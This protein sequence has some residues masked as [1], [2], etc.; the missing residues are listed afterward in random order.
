MTKTVIYTWTLNVSNYKP[1]DGS[2]Y[3]GIGD[4]LRGMIAC[5]VL[6]KKHNYNYIIDIQK[7]P[8]SKYLKQNN[9]EFIE[10]V[11]TNDDIPF[12]QTNEL[13]N[14]IQN[15]DQNVLMLMTNSLI[16]NN[17]K[18]DDDIKTMIMNIF[19]K[20]DSFAKYYEDC[21]Q[22]LNLDDEYY[23]CHFRLGDD[24]IVRNSSNINKV[25]QVYNKFLKDK[26]L[27]KRN[28]LIISDCMLLKKYISDK[29]S[30]IILFDAKEISHLGYNA[31]NIDMRDTMLEFFLIS[32]SKYIETFTVYQWTSGFV[33]YPSMLYDIPIKRL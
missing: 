20:N 14:Y 17:V 30:D 10:H 8:I 19:E 27:D 7:H 3:W 6:C 26:E 4:I 15:T 31:N 9:H 13:E 2:N 16:P 12:I 1:T 21:K 28:H 5:Y 11:K 18:I 29:R 25:E 23:I 22:E 24:Y 33:L 32:E